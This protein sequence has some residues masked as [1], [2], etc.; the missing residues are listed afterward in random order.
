MAN[1]HRQGREGVCIQWTILYGEDAD[2]FSLQSNLSLFLLR[3][4][5]CQPGAQEHGGDGMELPSQR[6]IF[7]SFHPPGFTPIPRNRWEILNFL[8]LFDVNYPRPC[9]PMSDSHRKAW[10]VLHCTQ[11][12]GAR[13]RVG[14]ELAARTNGSN[15]PKKKQE[16]TKILNPSWPQA[17][18]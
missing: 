4:L 15:G 16:K 18:E 7:S 17:Y 1:H 3:L 13:W 10:L 5:A 6:G 8:T 2:R 12:V 11:P 14:E 9:V